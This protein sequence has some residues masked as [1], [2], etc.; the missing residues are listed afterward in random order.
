MC[1]YTYSCIFRL[2]ECWNNGILKC[3]CFGQVY[4]VWMSAEAIPDE[5]VLEEILSEMDDD[6]SIIEGW[7]LAHLTNIQFNLHENTNHTDLVLH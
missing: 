4:K 6:T 2:D 1:M 3:A 5:E 7:W